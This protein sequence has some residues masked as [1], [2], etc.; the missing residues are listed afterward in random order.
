MIQACWR[1]WVCIRA[2]S[3]CESTAYPATDVVPHYETSIPMFRFLGGSPIGLPGL[4]RN[5]AKSPAD[6]WKDPSCEAPNDGI[7]KLLVCGCVRVVL[8]VLL[9]ILMSCCR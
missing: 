3:R 4:P 8:L 9:S 2:P 5:Q 1:I 7:L 6:L